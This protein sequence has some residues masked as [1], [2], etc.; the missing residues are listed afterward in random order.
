MGLPEAP[1]DDINH[2]G[3]L[4][5]V[6][7]LNVAILIGFGLNDLLRHAGIKLPLFVACLLTAIALTNV[8]PRLF[9]GLEWPSRTRGLALISNLALNVFLSMSLM[10]MQ[11]WTLGGLGP[12][13]VDVLAIQTLAAILYILFVVFPAMGGTYEAAVIAAGFGSVSLGATPTA[14]ANMTAVTKIYGAARLGVFH[15]PGEHRRCQRSGSLTAAS[16]GDDFSP[17]RRGSSPAFGRG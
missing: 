13:L 12:A 3:L 7:V 15:R 17:K 9:P 5:T 10:S 16:R 8:V 6:L 1:E 11:L 14:I 4:R 2:V